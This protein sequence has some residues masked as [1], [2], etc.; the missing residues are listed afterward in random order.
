[1]YAENLTK[2]EDAN[3]KCHKTPHDECFLCGLLKHKPEG[4][5]EVSSPDVISVAHFQ[6]ELT[7]LRSSHG[8]LAMDLFSLKLW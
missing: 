8:L 6:E 1:M 3:T 2:G 5:S 7:E 4:M